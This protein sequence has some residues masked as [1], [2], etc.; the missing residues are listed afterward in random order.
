MGLRLLVVEGNVREAREAHKAT[1]GKTPSDSYADTLRAL[2]HDAV[3]DVCLPTDAGANLPDSGGLAGYDGVAV[4]GSALNMYDGG[5]AIE[6][7]IELARAVYRSGTP[8]FGSCWGLQLGATAAGGTVTKNP[9]GSEIGVARNIARTAAG[10]S[11][12]LLAGR[13]AAWDAPCY[14]LDI[15]AIPP[16]E[17]TILAAN[18]NAPIQAAEIRHEGGVFWGVQYHPEY[19]LR[20]MSCI[21]RRRIAPLM[22]QGFFRD[23]A[24]GHALCDDFDALHEDS[25]RADIAWSRGLQPEMIDADLRLIEIR[26]W[27]ELCVKPEKSRRGRA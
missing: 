25:S 13:G 4:T 20:E 21:I 24:A 19:S 22:R 11:H 27:I 12:P 6:R 9:A 8:F 5:E 7:Q 17:T 23:E 14:H 2:A 10:Q 3:V 1:Y 16:G 15:V 26:N 18:A